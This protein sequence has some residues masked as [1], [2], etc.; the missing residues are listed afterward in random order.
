M[1]TESCS[2]LVAGAG[3]RGLLR[4]LTAR[5]DTPTDSLLVVDALPE[6]GGTLHSQRTN[7]FTCELGAFAFSRDEVA[8]LL[9]RLPRPPALVPCLPSAHQGW[10]WDGERLS[11]VPVEPAPCAFR[12]GNEELVQACR[13]ELA[14]VLRLGRPITSLRP[15][16]G[17]WSIGL[18]GQVPATLQ[19]TRLH[20]ALPVPVAATLL[21]DLDPALAHLVPRLRYAER[22]FVFFGAWERDVP[23]LSGYGVLPAAGVGSPVGEAIFCTQVFAARALPGMA[24]VRVE[25]EVP[26][27]ADDAA[28]AALAERELCHWTG[29]RPGFALRKVH[30]FRAP[31]VDAVHVEAAARLGGLA[32]RAPGLELAP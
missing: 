28:I 16:D 21:A 23:E 20:L 19:A 8:P 4:A 13:R 30:R 14:P 7:G 32:A 6:P 5:R 22:A 27:E 9:A 31:L 24:L 29:C 10:S 18:G 26:P 12:T 15:T 25:L 1:P 11:P 3:L 2:L 17:G